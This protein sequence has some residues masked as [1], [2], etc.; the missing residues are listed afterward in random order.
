MRQV[1]ELA[2]LH[3]TARSQHALDA[4]GRLKLK[5]PMAAN[6]ANFLVI[7]RPRQ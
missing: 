7:G 4:D 5:V 1:E 6:G 3:S 2:D